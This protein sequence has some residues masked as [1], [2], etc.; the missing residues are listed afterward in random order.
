MIFC[1]NDVDGIVDK[2]PP[3]THHILD[4]GAF[5]QIRA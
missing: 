3:Y 4:I 5:V 1:I 2:A